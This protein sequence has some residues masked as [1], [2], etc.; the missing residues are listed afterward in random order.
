MGVDRV[1]HG[2]SADTNESVATTEAVDGLVGVPEA[3][4]VGIVKVAIV[5]DQ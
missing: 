4:Y 3:A 2:G 5:G 1:Y